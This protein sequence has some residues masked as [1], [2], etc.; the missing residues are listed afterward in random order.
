MVVKDVRKGVIDFSTMD[1]A[2][3]SLCTKG[4]GQIESIA[5]GGNT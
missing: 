4:H 5:V 2:V 3:C 1:S